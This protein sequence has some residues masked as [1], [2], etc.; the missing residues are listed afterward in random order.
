VTFEIDSQ[1]P[2]QNSNCY[3]HIHSYAHMCV[4]FCMERETHTLNMAKC[5]KLVTGQRVHCF[6]DVIFFYKF[7]IV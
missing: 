2:W 4:Y 7:P 6:I 5:S 3:T 1:N